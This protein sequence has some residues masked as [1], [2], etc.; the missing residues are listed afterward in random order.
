MDR[1]FW[2]NRWET[3]D[4]P[5]HEGEANAFL[6]RYFATLPLPPAARV[7][8]P[9]CGKTRDIAWLL[10]QGLRVV[11]AELIELAITDLFAELRLKP[12]ISTIGAL[13]RYSAAGIEIFVGDIFDLTRDV[14]GDVDAVHDRAALVALPP[15]LR[16]RYAAHLIQIT[17]AAPQLLNCFEYDQNLMR[18]PP[19]SVEAD[20][21]ARL[22]GAAYQV[23]LLERVVVKGGLRGQE[24]QNAVWVLHQT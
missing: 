22:Y 16:A 23:T 4:I 13:Q 15:D 14:L 3:N 11:G 21:V 7:F 20:E 9:L 12:D 17:G 8:V 2:L 24:A 6:V 5:F 19:F 10:A 1:D 18:G